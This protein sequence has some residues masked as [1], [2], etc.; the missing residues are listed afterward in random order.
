MTAAPTPSASRRRDL[1]ID[2]RAEER[3]DEALIP[4]LRE[5][6]STRVLV[7]HGDAAP[8]TS[9]GGLL[10]VEVGAV[11]D[12]GEWAFLGRDPRG[13]G[14][15]LAAFD[16]LSEPPTP[17]PHGWGALR[18]V[19]G[20]LPAG[21]ASLFVTA[22][23]LG[24]WLTDAAYCP[25]CGTRT[26]ERDSGW[27]RHCPSC[28][29][30]HF[31]RTDPAVIVAVTSPDDSD[32]L[33]LGSNALWGENRYSCFAGFAEAG[34]SLEDAVARE[35][36]EEAGI[37]V[38][39]VQYRGSQGWPYPR[40]LMLGFRASAAVPAD[41]RPDGEE[42]V[43]VRWFTRAEIGASLAGESE[44]LLPGPASIAH[45]LISEWHAETS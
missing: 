19:A 35:V 36:G 32:V 1:R 10:L 24:R 30:Q 28:S 27:S 16:A 41:A 26:A 3:A 12:H 31:P 23:A 44:L 11:A 15:L 34:E 13:A 38:A 8:L 2:S 25:A 17:A 5:E 37:V 6:G 42:I 7:V 40:S 20:G 43:A 14:V 18:S 9:E 45:R 39:D 4:T 22:V 29:R 33:L 21:E